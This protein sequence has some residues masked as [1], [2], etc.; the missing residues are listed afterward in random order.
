[1]QNGYTQIVE[2]ALDVSRIGDRHRKFAK[3]FILTP[4][5]LGGMLEDRR[6]SPSP[7]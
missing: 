1:L 4:S 6:M 2:E 7:M 5:A 3:S